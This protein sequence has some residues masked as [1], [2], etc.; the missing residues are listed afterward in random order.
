MPGIEHIFNFF[1]K[2]G[3]K[4]GLATSSAPVVIDAVVELLGY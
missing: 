4:I 3:F 2:Q 1:I